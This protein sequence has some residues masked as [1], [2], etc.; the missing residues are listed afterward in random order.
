MKR[1]LSVVTAMFLLVW[2]FGFAAEAALGTVKYDA[3]NE[4][5]TVQG[6][7]G[8]QMQAICLEVLAG[9][10]TE[11]QFN[12]ADAEEQFNMLVYADETLSVA[13]GSWQ[14]HFEFP[15]DS[16]K[17]IVRVREGVKG[18]VETRSIVAASNEEFINAMEAINSADSGNMSEALKEHAGTLGLDGDT[19]MRLP[20]KNCDAMAQRILNERNKQQNQV[21]GN[22]EL[23]EAVFNENLAVE[24]VNA[25]D[26]SNM[27]EVLDKYE[28]YFHYKNEKP[29][30]IFE[31]L[32]ADS[33]K[34]VYA[35][36]SKAD[37]GS[38]AEIDAAFGLET[39][40]VRLAAVRGYD[41][42]YDVLPQCADA[43]G[44]N[45][46]K[47]TALSKENQLK[48]CSKITTS[49]SGK[50]VTK[51]SLEQIV[52]SAAEKYS[53]GGTTENSRPGNNGG[54]NGGGRVPSGG[55]SQTPNIGFA[56]SNEPYGDASIFHDIGSVSWARE[57]IE[58]LAKRGVINGKSE[59]IFAPD[60]TVTREEFVKMV[61]LALN[62]TAEDTNCNFTD[63]RDDTWYRE[64]IGRAV[65]SGIVKGLGDGTF[66][67][68]ENISRQDIAV[69][70]WNAIE[71]K[72][73]AGNAIAFDDNVNVSDYAKEAVNAMRYLKIID[74]YEDNTFR[75]NNAAT[76]AEAA[77]LLYKAVQIAE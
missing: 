67:V 76:R 25:A 50:A 43:L 62:I 13:D 47:Y 36:L 19:L 46:S 21:F 66:G 54:G 31:G 23:L 57:S 63:V 3:E 71:N 45:I 35:N 59:K 16:E 69:I 29:Y 44:A 22:Y 2:N 70:L 51:E 28:A 34:N 11:E 65:G 49:L 48:I 75:P 8:S 1:Y 55:T 17:H 7:A 26:E 64:Y 18:A 74:G 39:V 38:P 77:K 4:I 15:G 37:Y 40:R 12:A 56:T 5:L 73:R 10:V 20:Q 52:S 58:E 9:G 41:E 61:V 27:A 32:S 24:C 14:F 68:G 53:S 42:L 6:N 72:T 60:D 33:R 30:Q